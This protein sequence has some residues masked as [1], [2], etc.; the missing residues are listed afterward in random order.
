MEC[1][2][3][4]TLWRIIKENSLTMANFFPHI[5]LTESLLFDGT[6]L[7]SSSLEN[8]GKELYDIKG[9]L[10]AENDNI[11]VINKLH[12]KFRRK[13]YT[14]E[15]RIKIEPGSTIGSTLGFHE[16][17]HGLNKEWRDDIKVNVSAK[18]QDGTLRHLLKVSS[19]NR[20]KVNEYNEDR[21]Y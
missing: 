16:L 11:S 3:D 1:D 8:Y 21:I 18:Y 12:M 5:R 7:C 10:L 15:S 4:K 9:I 14:L 6:I 19:K 20:H 2:L 17:L 13:S